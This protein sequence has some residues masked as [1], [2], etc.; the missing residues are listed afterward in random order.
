MDDHHPAGFWSVKAGKRSTIFHPCPSPY[1]IPY[2]CLYSK[3]V[4]NLF[5]AGRNVSVTHAALS[6]T[7][8]IGTCISMAQ[9]VGTAA[10]LASRKK[11]APRGINEHVDELQQ[12]LLADDC[13]LPRVRQEFGRLT[14][15]AELS[16]SLGDPEPVRDGTN[17][18]V[19]ETA[20]CWEGGSGDW[21]A[22]SFKRSTMV[23][24]AVLALDS[25][26]DKD[27][28]FFDFLHDQPN[29]SVP[30]T[31]AKDFRI[32]GLV[33]G[34]WRTLETVKENYQRFVRVRL[35]RK[36]SGVRFKL[37]KTWGAKRSR[38]FNFHVA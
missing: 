2:R 18:S 25:S 29:R 5:F 10:A 26:L 11:L 4:A 7:R 3:N 12:L 31:M 13:Y 37:L 35:G 6:S 1:G 14:A 8:V 36:L 32:E 34:K 28:T 17:R 24:E 33:G 22:Y 20:H 9:A 21:L 16:A 23:K 15:G 38:V 30:G 27:I 19:G